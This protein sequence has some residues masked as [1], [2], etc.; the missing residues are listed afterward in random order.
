VGISKTKG[1]RGKG[2]KKRTQNI[3]EEKKKVE[4]REGSLRGSKGGPS[5]RQAR[6]VLGS[7][8]MNT[9]GLPPKAL[10]VPGGGK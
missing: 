3:K 8:W 2:T 6:K 5:V 4:V 10:K 9:Y 7:T 1:S